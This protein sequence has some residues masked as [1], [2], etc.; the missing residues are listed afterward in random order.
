MHI[1]PLIRKGLVVGIILLFGM[2]SITLSTA[3]VTKKP[4]LTSSGRWLYVGGSG[5]GNYTNIQDAID[6]ASAGDTV[7]V[8]D[9]SSP[10]YENIWINTSLHLIGE[11][12][13]T[14][15]VDARNN[16]SVITIRQGD[17]V[18]ITGF[19]LMNCGD[20][21]Y[22]ESRWNDN[23]ITALGC[24]YLVIKENCIS[25]GFHPMNE[26]YL[27]GILLD[28]SSN[29]TIQK[30]IIYLDEDVIRSGGI[31]IDV[32]SN[33]NNVS[34][35]EIYGYE[36]GI[37]TEGGSNNIF[38]ENVMYHNGCG[39][40]L[41]KSDYTTILKNTLTNNS[42]IVIESCYH[43][44]IS[45][46]TITDNSGSG[47]Y[48]QWG[49]SAYN[50][51]E[52]NNISQNRHGIA[53]FQWAYSYD[54][55]IADNNILNNSGTGITLSD[56]SHYQIVRNNLINNG[57]NADFVDYSLTRNRWDG[58]Y[59]SDYRGSGFFPK[60]IRGTT[61][62]FSFFPWCAFDWHPALK[63]YDIPVMCYNCVNASDS[64]DIFL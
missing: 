50:T 15:I 61:G 9:N 58:N 33:N 3:Q 49:P 4:T 21:T 57:K 29:S 51:I 54:T 17:H 34:A 53:F 41:L 48:F 31:A 20:G 2:T 30:N 12:K 62:P 47:I 63:P 22:P 10:Y 8:Y 26:N 40:F 46:N 16:G 64:K 60:I 13:Q 23:V 56:C 18:L 24:K 55:V 37:F 45:W 5:L 1:N 11:N 59:W 25:I 44:M 52:Y 7:F 32:Y 27:A 39:I 6:T 35:N 14:T 43:S 42:G 36:F 19:T 38:Y 28:A